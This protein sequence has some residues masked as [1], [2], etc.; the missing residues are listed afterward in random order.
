MKKILLLGASGSIGTQTLD[1]VD[2]HPEDYEIVALSVGDNLSFLIDTLRNKKINKVCIKDESRIHEIKESFPEVEV[3]SGDDGLLELVKYCD[4]D[5]LV[6]ALVGFVGF[7]PT[8]HAILTDHD[9]ALANKESLVVG[10]ELIKKAL[11]EHDVELIPVDSEHSAIYQS[12]NG[13][14][15]EDVKRLIVTAS[16]GAF[17]DKSR[18]ELKD[19]TL[20]DALKHPNW[21]MGEKITVDSA[22][23]MNKGFEVIEAH[24]LFD[25]DYENIDVLIHKESII[26]S[27]VEYIDGSVI[28][29]LATADM[30]L[31]IQY[32]LSKPKRLENPS[33]EGLDLVKVG[34]LHFDDVD[35]R[36][37]P[38]IALAYEAGKKGGN[39]PAVMN[40]ANDVANLAFR[41]GEISFLDIEDIIIKAVNYA[42][43]IEVNS[44]DDLIEANKFGNEF[45]LKEI[46]ERNS[47]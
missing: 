42:K 33:N 11:E 9:V 13:N 24:Y 29:Q 19:V 17:R 28:A 43:Y 37:Y 23:M 21:L 16:G 18:E 36:R 5:I 46:K 3:L 25:V 14:R 10:G 35:V 26:H 22:T 38:L 20:E 40:G 12:L 6:N 47:K 32:A 15:K 39:L 30:R 7:L 4:Y 44:V 27:M 8:Y 31:P 41:K 45:A 34:S 1:I 2:K